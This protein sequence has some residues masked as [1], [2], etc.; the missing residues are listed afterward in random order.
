ME[1]LEEARR[2]G[3]VSV[4]AIRE[5]LPP[6][7]VLVCQHALSVGFGIEPPRSVHDCALVLPAIRGNDLTVAHLLDRL[8]V[9]LCRLF[10]S[11]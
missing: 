5:L 9:D 3:L 2:H 11:H 8:L 4:G 7:K 6:G 1:V 10:V